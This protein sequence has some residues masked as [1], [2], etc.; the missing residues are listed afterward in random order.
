[1][2]QRT[3]VTIERLSGVEWFSKVGE[4][5]E[6]PSIIR[7]SSWSEAMKHCESDEWQDLLLEAANRYGEAIAKRS[8]EAY[9]RWN[10]VADSLRP[11]VI[12]LVE[13]KTANV[14]R[15]NKLG[16]TF[17]ATVQWDVIHLLIEAEFA[18]VHPPGFFASQAYWYVEGRFP[19][20]WQ[21]TF[22][23]GKLVVY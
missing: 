17:K 8:R 23:D 20:G 12:D 3:T 11:L 7:V 22:P 1:M 6:S 4:C 9:S 2:H 18:D 10:T 13:R 5:L 21:G 15:A 19:C 14:I 16:A